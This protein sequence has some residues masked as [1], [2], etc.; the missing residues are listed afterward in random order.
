MRQLHGLKCKLLQQLWNFD[1]LMVFEVLH[2]KNGSS[3]L[4]SSG[5]LNNMLFLH[6][7][8]FLCLFTF[9]SV[10][11]QEVPAHCL[12]PIYQKINAVIFATQCCYF[13]AF[14]TRFQIKQ[15]N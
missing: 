3:C 5:K 9:F 2:Y 4:Q 1:C 6:C 14:A 10:S 13:V 15:I 8:V 7:N 11:Y 12:C